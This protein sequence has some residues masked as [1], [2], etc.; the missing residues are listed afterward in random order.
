M[1]DMDNVCVDNVSVAFTDNPAVDA[2][3]NSNHDNGTQRR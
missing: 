3:N 1:N 2:N